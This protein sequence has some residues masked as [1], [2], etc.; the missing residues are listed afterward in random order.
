MKPFA[1]QVAV[2][3]GSGSGVGRAVALA[4][5][6]EGATLCLVGRTLEKLQA[7]A[8]LARNTTQRVECYQADL[9]RD[10]DVQELTTFLRGEFESLDLLVHSAGAIHIGQ[11]ANA[12]VDELDLQYRTNVRGPF[13]LTQQ[14]LPMLIARRGQVVFINSSA[15]LMARANVGQYA[16]SKHALKA[17]TDSLREEVNP[18]G[19]RVL[20]MFLGRT[21]TPMQATVHQMEGREYHPERLVQPDDVA[22]VVISVLRLPRT[23]EV[24]EISMR[25]ALK[26]Y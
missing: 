23:A 8:T 4:L 17:I 2:V 15:G 20:S 13:V 11:L 22:S 3:T 14:L 16:A 12:P 21:A 7:V 26:S 5:A 1:G 9:T 25:P 24:T 6:A 19:V 10:I 18:C